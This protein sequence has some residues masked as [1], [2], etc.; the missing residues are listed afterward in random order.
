MAA[1][2]KKRAL[3]D[4]HTSSSQ[5]QDESSSDAGKLEILVLPKNLAIQ[6]SVSNKE[7]MIFCKFSLL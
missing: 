2:L 4:Y 7:K 3:A 6:N 1:K 5:Y